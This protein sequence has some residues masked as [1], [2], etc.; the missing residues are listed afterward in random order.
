MIIVPLNAFDLPDCKD[1][2]DVEM[3]LV[4]QCGPIIP[5]AKQTAACFHAVLFGCQVK[6]G[7]LGMDQTDLFIIGPGTRQQ[8]MQCPSGPDCV[9]P[10]DLGHA[11]VP[12]AA[13]GEMSSAAAFNPPHKFCCGL[14]QFY[15][16]G[17]GLFKTLSS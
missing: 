17:A 5:S 6:V 9:A 11:S 13:A 4:P 1:Q 16:A 14:V 10:C 12:G 8:G 2:T 3:Y 7:F 15:G